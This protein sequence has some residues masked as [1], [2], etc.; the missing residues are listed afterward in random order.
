MNRKSDLNYYID[1]LEVFLMSHFYRVAT[2]VYLNN[3]PNILWLYV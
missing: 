1:L 3:L 2:C